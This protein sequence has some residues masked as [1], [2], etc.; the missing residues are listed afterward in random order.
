MRKS[1]ES[2]SS[3]AKFINIGQFLVSVRGAFIQV[4]FTIIIDISQI[5]S[6][7]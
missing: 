4:D 2:N 1:C 3:Q 5:L 6:V 7:R